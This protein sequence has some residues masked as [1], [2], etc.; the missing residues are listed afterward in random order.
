M[1]FFNLLVLL[2]TVSFADVF[3]SPDIP[4]NSELFYAIE[5][6]IDAD[7]GFL[8][9]GSTQTIISGWSG[10]LCEGDERSC[11]IE[12]AG[13]KLASLIYKGLAPFL[14]TVEDDVNYVVNT[15]NSQSG[16]C[17]DYVNR[18]LQITSYLD[19]PEMSF[20]K[21]RCNDYLDRISFY[22]DEISRLICSE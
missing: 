7:Q 3:D 9:C 10:Q 16:N 5:N 15:A 4:E 19:D 12:T 8:Q 11:F 22:A 13:H 18:Y 1:Y 14:P 20:V 6:Y 17:N 2:T 21:E